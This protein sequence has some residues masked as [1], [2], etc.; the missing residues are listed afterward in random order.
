MNAFF[1][2]V[3][4]NSLFL[5]G[6][7]TPTTSA[8]SEELK[9]GFHEAMCPMICDAKMEG[10][11]GYVVD[12]LNE[13]GKSKGI[14]VMVEILPKPRLLIELNANNIDFLL[15]PN[16]PIKKNNLIQT[17]QPIVF[18]T[19]GVMRR[20]DFAFQLTGVESLEKANWGIVNGTRWRP[21]YQRHIDKN[22]GNN[23]TEISGVNAYDRLTKMM[24]GKR[25]DVVI[26]NFEMLER[27]RKE[28]KNPEALIVEKTTVFGDSVPLYLAFSPNNKRA[29]SL[30]RFFSDGMEQ[31]RSS[32]KLKEL[33]LSYGIGD[34]A[35]Q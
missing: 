14:L 26:N 12:I 8:W 10:Q 32:T 9:F 1:R 13:I 35:E 31:I 29:E 34:H 5:Y 6:L 17:T 7:L 33:S 19:I 16:S 30:A 18:Y 27:K 4:L 24:L 20:K 15:L 25:I 28:S 2:N 21:A 22:K 23:V 3:L 11:R